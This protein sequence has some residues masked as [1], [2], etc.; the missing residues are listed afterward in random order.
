[1]PSGVPVEPRDPLAWIQERWVLLAGLALFLLVVWFGSSEPRRENG[2]YV[3]V[4]DDVPCQSIEDREGDGRRWCYLLLDT[5]SGD[6]EERLR[7]FRP[8]DRR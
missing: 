8:R 2:R 4:K 5:Q 6:L 3:L 7:K 1:M